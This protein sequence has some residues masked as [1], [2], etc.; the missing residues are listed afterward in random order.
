V[1]SNLR[2]SQKRVRGSEGGLTTVRDDIQSSYDFQLEKVIQEVKDRK[3]KR[4]LLQFPDGLLQYASRIARDISLKT[5]SQAIVS[6]DS[7]YGACDLATNA[8]SRL[9]ADLIVH[10]GHARLAGKFEIPTIFVEAFSSLDVMGILP[11]IKRH[12]G[13]SKNIGLVSTVQ[14]VH[15]L[16]KVKD[17]LEKN[18]LR[19]YV[20]K[21]A[22]KV[23]YD[24]QVLGCDYSTAKS[25]SD[26][27]DKFVIVGG[28][29][30]H[31]IGLAM[32]TKKECI[33]ADP[34]SG[35]VA[36]TIED[37]RTYLKSR[38]AYI[39]E[40]KKGN[41]FGVVMGLKFGQFD[42]A[43]ALRARN[44]FRKSGRNVVLFCAD[45]LSPDRLNSISD[46]DAFVIAACP[47]IAIDD[48]ALF[49]KPVLTVDE[50]EILFSD[51][52]LEDYLAFG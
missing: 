19:V 28:G 9:A 24:G 45:N 8:A 23:P 6:L 48:A 39:M 4:I 33:I 22:G 25:I 47:R 16:G 3:S 27:V 5:D 42:E 34:Y 52:L 1:F 35:T 44:A 7:C 50:S 38:Y 32:A 11:K 10:Y 31:A 2:N 41:T 18:G 15:L 37:L 36:S 49:R 26:N 30:F 20:G 46:I 17:Y 21:A 43:R 12:I 51:R 13:D 29:K 14:H 40:A